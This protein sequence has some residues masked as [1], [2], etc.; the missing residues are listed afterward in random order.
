MSA[1]DRVEK[2]LVSGIVMRQCICIASICADDPEKKAL[3]SILTCLYSVFIFKFR[4]F[5]IFNFVH[6][7]S[8][9][10]HDTNF[11]NRQRAVLCLILCSNK[12]G[13]FYVLVNLKLSW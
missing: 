2:L 12:Q 11:I 5:R 9:P 13:V 6:S 10:L 1:V 3:A 4:Y 8:P 7:F